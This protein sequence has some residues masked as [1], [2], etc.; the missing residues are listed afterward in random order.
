MNSH[1]P[2]TIAR[3]IARLNVGGPAVQAILMTDS[4]RRRGYRTLLFSGR[5]APGEEEMDYLARERGVVPIRIGCLSRKISIL[6]DLQSLWQLVRF[7]RRE[8]PTIVHTHTAKA[9]TL[10]RIAAIIASVPIRVHTFHGHVFHG[11]FP[12][13]LTRVFIGIERFLARHTHA[14]VAISESQKNELA[15]VYKIA[16]AEKIRIVPLGFSMEKLLG[17]KCREPGLRSSLGV[18]V[19]LPL[20]GWIGRL[21][22]IKDPQLFLESAS[23][24]GSQAKFVIVGDGELRDACQARI[25]K[26]GLRDKVVLLGWRR[27]LAPVYSDLDVLVM[28]SINEGTPL[29]LLEAMAAAKPFVATDVGGVRDLMVGKGMPEQGWERFENGILTPR[30]PRVIARAIE[31]LLGNEKLRNELGRAGREFVRSRYSEERL[32]N[33]LEELYL[34]LACTNHCIAANDPQ[35]TSPLPNSP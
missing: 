18:G 9:G 6:N 10:G 28:T 34:W 31:H 4:F 32:T 35:S 17:G 22:G 11:Y 16:S 20:V 8:R 29:A 30:D 21:T 5:I 7:F 3:V 15:A 12:R 27:D 25:S 1:A 14:I 26:N 19:D 33:D 23:L 13:W 24:A 2:I